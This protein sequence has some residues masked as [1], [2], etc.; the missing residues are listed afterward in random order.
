MNRQSI[1][2][3]LALITFTAVILFVVYGPTEV[4]AITLTTTVYVTITEKKFIT[5]IEKVMSLKVIEMFVF[6]KIE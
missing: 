4:E 3:H 1:S 5:S 2:T 6:Y